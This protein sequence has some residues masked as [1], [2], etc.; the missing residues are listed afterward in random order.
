[1]DNKIKNKLFK[2]QSLHSLNSFYVAVLAKRSHG[3]SAQKSIPQNYS[4][5]IAA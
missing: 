1:M 2:H 3:F 5:K 4:L